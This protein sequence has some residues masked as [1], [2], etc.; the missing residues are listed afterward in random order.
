MKNYF[1]YNNSKLHLL[2]HIT[3]WVVV[4]LVHMLIFW[5]VF[6]S[7]QLLLRALTNLFFLSFIFYF[8]TRILVNHIL[9]KQKYTYYI[10]SAILL[11]L[12]MIP[13]RTAVNLQFAPPKTDLPIYN[14]ENAFRLVTFITNL[15]IVLFSTIYQ[16]LVNRLESERKVLNT[17][18]QN[19]EAQLQFLRSQI[20]PHFLF[21]T[22]NNIYSLAVTKSDK[23]A[24]MVVKLS[25]LL[26]Y[27][28]YESE[29]EQVL[30]SEELAQIEQFI[31]LYQM[32]NE[33]PHKITFEVR[34]IPNNAMIEPM[35]LIPIVEN[36]FK[37]CDFET[38]EAAYAKISA[39][40]KNGSIIFKTVNTK[41][42]NNLQKDK[43]GGVGLENIR[44]R[45]A[46]KQG[47]NWRL[48]TKDNGETFET[49]CSLPF[50]IQS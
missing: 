8:N 46:L 25:N 29:E 7:D 45:L 31:E 27:V 36:C 3:F 18:N 4:G 35:V 39:A 40:T 23:T 14:F 13:I 1:S 48:E 33:T 2:L 11:I 21:N 37:H 9:E 10:M 44:K 38:N 43:V 32:R 50:V 47:F 5:L 17:L 16:V 12:I 30:L 34:G 49:K 41:N 42:D 28:I 24:S 22:L 15:C 26:R 20:N 19:K 6:E